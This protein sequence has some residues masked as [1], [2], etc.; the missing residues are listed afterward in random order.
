MGGVFC[1]TISV[2]TIHEL[3][4]ILIHALVEYMYDSNTSKCTQV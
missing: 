2:C 1:V 4:V 3:C